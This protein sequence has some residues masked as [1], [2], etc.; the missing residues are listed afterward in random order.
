M[1]CVARAVTPR[2]RFVKTKPKAY[3]SLAVLSS[4]FLFLCWCFV[5]ESLPFLFSHS[6]LVSVPL[7]ETILV[8]C[9]VSHLSVFPTS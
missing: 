7:S 3:T 6:V 1:T 9:W 2:N 8:S 4:V 5:I